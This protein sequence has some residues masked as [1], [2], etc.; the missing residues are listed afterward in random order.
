MDQLSEDIFILIAGFLLFGAKTVRRHYFHS[1]SN[2]TIATK[3]LHDLFNC[4][5]C[6]IWDSLCLQAINAKH[7][8]KD[9]QFLHQVLR[10]DHVEMTKKGCNIQLL[11]KKKFY[12]YYLDKLCGGALVTFGAGMAGQLGTASPF[13]SSHTLGY[14]TSQKKYGEPPLGEAPVTVA[15][16]PVV[17]CCAGGH[18]TTVV[19]RYA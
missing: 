1:L 6:R 3:Y 18:S 14:K 9:P 5:K 2:L 15:C 10:Y 8:F 13:S 12:Y 17:Q 4:E 7:I 11:K 16:E 19:T